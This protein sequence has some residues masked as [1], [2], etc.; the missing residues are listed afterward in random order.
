MYSK[1]QV[2]IF[3]GKMKD[4]YIQRGQEASQRAHSL[5][6][7]LNVRA[8]VCVPVCVHACIFIRHAFEE[9]EVNP[10]CLQEHS[11]SLNCCRDLSNT[12]KWILLAWDPLPATEAR[13]SSAG[14]MH[15]MLQAGAAPF[16]VPEPAVLTEP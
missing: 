8:C 11:R 5:F 16:P 15:R 14:W 10:D 7:N 3:T 6:L 9:E 1:K 13:G 12:P 4:R 2:S